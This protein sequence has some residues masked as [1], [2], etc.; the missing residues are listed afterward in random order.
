[1]PPVTRAGTR[2]HRGESMISLILTLAL[3]GVILY[4]IETFVPVPAPF[5]IAIRVIVII[6]L[7]LYL[8]RIFGL[9]LPLPTVR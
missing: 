8:V 7:I 4:L 1:V 2:P 5:K 6:V 9:D 3:V